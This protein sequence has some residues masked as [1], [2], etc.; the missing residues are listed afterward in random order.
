MIVTQ[1]R[2]KTEYKNI[3]NKYAKLVVVV[4]R[5]FFEESISLLRMFVYFLDVLPLK[6]QKNDDFF[7][8]CFFKTI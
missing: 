3:E 6:Q 7:F 1:I 8:Y 5:L 4:H 2:L